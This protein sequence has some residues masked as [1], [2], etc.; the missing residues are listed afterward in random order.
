MRIL[1][2]LKMATVGRSDKLCINQ[3]RRKKDQDME[4]C[5]ASILAHQVPLWENIQKK[6]EKM[7]REYPPPLVPQQRA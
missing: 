1:R 4:Q 3:P 2:T 7:F 6:V 5:L